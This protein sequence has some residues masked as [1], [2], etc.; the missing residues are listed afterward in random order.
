MIVEWIIYYDDGTTFS[1]QNGEP[2]EAPREGAQVLATRNGDVGRALWFGVDYFCWQDGEW[3][4][5]NSVGLHHYLR[6]PGPVKIVVQGTGIAFERFKKILWRA[7]SEEN[8]LPEKSGRLHE[9]LE[10]PAP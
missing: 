2:H 3:V 7:A 4:P 8:Q 1:S 10:M 6:Q 9:E 5:R